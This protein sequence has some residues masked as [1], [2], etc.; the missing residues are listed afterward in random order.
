VQ[1]SRAATD[2]R[3]STSTTSGVPQP[4]RG[5]A[6]VVVDV[7]NDF[8]S[9]SL[10]VPDAAAVIAPLNRAVATFRACGLPVFATRDW[11]PPDHCS[12]VAQGGTWPVHCVA[13]TPGADYAPGFK[14]GPDAIPV[15][16][17]TR[18]DA[19][20]Y[21]TF[22]GT[23]LANELRTRGV[24]RLFIGGLATDYCVL[25]STRD[26]LAEGFAVVVLADAVRAVDV[27]PGDGLR[28][29]AEMRRLGAHFATVAE[30]VSWR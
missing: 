13:G 16:K 10:A 5:D 29:E 15:Y 19:E 12:F 21:S 3:P 25:N 23:P 20:A 8:V 26:A 7:Q 17:G 30:I 1:P 28:A 4:G 11:H 27:H 2:H 9:G 14:L 24:H 6:L 22:A 18:T